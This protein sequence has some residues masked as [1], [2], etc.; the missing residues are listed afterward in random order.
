MHNMYIYIYVIMFIH[1][2]MHTYVYI[3]I[4]VG[5]TIGDCPQIPKVGVSTS[6]RFFSS[7][8]LG[9]CSKKPMLNSGADVGSGAGPL[10]KAAG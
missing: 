4:W 3:Y 7:I 10:G 9:I 8:R 5:P 2:H 1:T 6:I